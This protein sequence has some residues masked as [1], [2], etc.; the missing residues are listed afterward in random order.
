MSGKAWAGTLW[1]PGLGVGL[2]PGLHLM[3]EREN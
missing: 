3:D 1:V 2:M